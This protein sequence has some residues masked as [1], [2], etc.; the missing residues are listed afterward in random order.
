MGKAAAFFDMDHTITWKNA[1]LSSV[2]FA[3]RQGMVPLGFLLTGIV[4][5]ALYRLSLL[6]I[7]QWYER[8]MSLLAGLPLEDMDRFSA[9]WFEAMIRKSIYREAV[10]LVRSHQERGHHLVVIS[11]SPPFFVK[12]LALTLGVADIITTQVEAVNGVL[13]GKLVKPLCYGKGKREYALRW[14]AQNNIDLSQSYFYTD[15]F[16]DIDFL[17]DVGFPVAA[18]PDRRLR[19]AALANRWTIM[20]FRRESAF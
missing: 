15:S 3:R 2:Q 14:S 4:K 8:N 5:I 20:D 19:R 18:N 9:A 7:E 1:G 6:N 12:Q 13:T 17:H 16:Y 11:N 10:D